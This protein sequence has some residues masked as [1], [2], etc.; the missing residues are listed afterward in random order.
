MKIAD[1]WSRLFGGRLVLLSV[2]SPRALSQCLMGLWAN[3]TFE[4]RQKITHCD[5]LVCVLVV[6]TITWVFIFMFDFKQLTIPWSCGIPWDCAIVCLCLVSRT[7]L[8]IPMLFH[9]WKVHVS[10]NQSINQPINQPIN[11]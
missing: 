10:I 3:N 8:S 6:K 9:V 5:Y 7:L 11:Q 4:I 2:T 1:Y